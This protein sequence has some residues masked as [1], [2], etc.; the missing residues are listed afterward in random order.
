M[1]RIL[2]TMSSRA[3]ESILIINN[4]KKR[5]EITC[6][7]VNSH[8]FSPSA[9]HLYDA[10]TWRMYYRIIEARMKKAQ[11]TNNASQASTSAAVAEYAQS[12][13]GEETPVKSGPATSS[14]SKTLQELY[15][16]HYTFDFPKTSR[17]T[18][19]D[20]VASEASIEPSSNHDVQFHLEF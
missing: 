15:D 18:R 13:V 7:P 14:H 2:P 17:R 12:T 1:S 9:Y 3:T 16:N 6:D 10:A 11:A 19:I 8:S 5:Y 4:K 20:S